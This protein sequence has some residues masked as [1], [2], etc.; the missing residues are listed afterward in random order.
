MLS[1]TIAPFVAAAFLAGCAS[2]SPKDAIK[3]VHTAVQE[4]SG[5]KVH[6]NRGTE[7]DKKAEEAIDKLLQRDLTVDNAVQI[8]LISNASLQ[9]KFE[10]LAISQADLVEAGLLSN[11]TLT[12]G[13]TAWEA[14]HISPNL[15]ASVEQSFLDLL[16]MPM[17]KRVAATELEA[18][19][20]DLGHEV[21]KLAA[22]V[23][24]AY[25]EALA[26]EQVAKMRG[27]VDDASQTSAEI[28]HRQ[29][30]AGNM[31]DLALN[32]ELSLF[33][34]TTLD[35]HRATGEAAVAREKLNKLMGLWGR[36]TG[37]KMAAKLPELPKAEDSLENLESKAIEQRL[38]IGAARRNVQAM[39]SV[40]SLAKTTRWVG[41][42]NVEVEAGR[43]RHNRRFSFGPSV[44]LEI[45]LFNQRQAQ[46]AKLEAYKRQ[47]ESSLRALSVDA[48]ADVRSARARV[49][50]ARAV[51]E[52]YAKSIVPLREKVVHFSQEQYDAM[53]VGVY[54]LIEAKRSEYDAYRAYIEALRDYWVA[55]SDLELAVGGRVGAAPKATPQPP[56][57]PQPAAAPAHSHGG[58]R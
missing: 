13:R 1:R 3:D 21:L 14:E 40:L 15:F 50:T 12:F 56:A 9:A 18:A 2:T 17:R 32:T 37:W 6:W 7:E 5:H 8:A 44:S 22:E 23:R 29:Y 42:I 25:Y 41:S 11:P 49:I 51:V 16:T 24:Q 53:L 34:E 55:R 28:A 38:D 52:Q 20:L 27:L 31:S 39:S 54:Q 19:K 35:R 45:P 48:R 4:R 57:A 36:R 26:A 30:D 46:I 43:L 47:A 58:T 33:A 10:E